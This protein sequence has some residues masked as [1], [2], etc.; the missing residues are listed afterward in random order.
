MAE[1]KLDM[2][3]YMAMK[4]LE[5]QLKAALEREKSWTAKI[6]EFNNEK[7]KILEDSK[8]KVLNITRT[9]STETV[10]KMRKDAITM[11]N[12]FDRDEL[13]R[14]RNIG[15]N[16][17]NLIADRL[18]EKVT[19]H[20]IPIEKTTFIGL[21]EVEERIRIKA[22]AQVKD[23]LDRNR[24]RLVDKD[25]KIGALYENIEELK[26][27]LEIAN[28]KVNTLAE[29][30]QT[31]KRLSKRVIA[32]EFATKDYDRL[33]ILV[34]SIQS[35]AVTSGIF[36]IFP[37]MNIIQN[38]ISDYYKLQEEEAKEEADKILNIKS[39]KDV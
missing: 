34:K 19:I 26:Q 3:E 24:D 2:T 15:N 12:G 23:R 39:D 35:I 8:M 1:V 18:F 17:A 11:F 33:K 7:I 16:P 29:K 13:L 21:D 32:L 20:T 37:A 9:E 6:E 10:L 4:D 25:K 14:Q 31:I 5:T 38:K 36:K 30:E 22:E 27:D 28:I